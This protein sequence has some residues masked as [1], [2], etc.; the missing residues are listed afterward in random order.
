MDIE[1][2]CMAGMT[3]FSRDFCCDT[4]PKLGGRLQMEIGVKLGLNLSVI[5][6]WNLQ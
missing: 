2:L 1:I 3:K 6:Q 4:K 5:C